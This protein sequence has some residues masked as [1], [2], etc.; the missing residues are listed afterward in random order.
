MFYYFAIILE[1][2]IIFLFFP[3]NCLIY[4]DLD[5]EI[6]TMSFWNFY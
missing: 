6:V 2:L 1:K 5:K 4:F 3:L